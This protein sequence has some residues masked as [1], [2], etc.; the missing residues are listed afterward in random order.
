MKI[1]I[2]GAGYVGLVT[3]ACFAEMGHQVICLD[4]D[5]KKIESLQ[6]GKVP[7]YEPGLE[8]LIIRNVN[9]GRLSFTTDYKKGVENALFCFLAVPTPS[10]EEGSC[11]VKH[12]LEAAKDIAQF[13]NGYKIVVVKSTVP[14]G[15]SKLVVQKIEETLVK[16]DS[17]L[18]FDVVSNPEFLKEGDAIGDFMKPDRIVIGLENDKV[19]KLMR[20]LY[21]PFNLSRD[22]ILVMDIASSEMTKYASNAMLASRISFMNELSHVCENLGA[23]I[24]KVRLGMGADHRIGYA[25]LYSGAGFGGSCFPKDIKALRAT[26]KKTGSPT[27]LLDAIE[28][29][30]TRQ[31]KVLYSKIRNYFSSKDG[32]QGKKLAIWGLAFKPGTDDLREAPSVVL[33]QDLLNAG[34]H[35]RI[36]D[37]VAMENAK[38][39]FGDHVFIEWCKDEQEAAFG[40]DGIVLVTEWKQFRFV[41]FPALLPHMRGS[42]FFDG[43]NQYHPEEMQ[44]YGFDY[45]SIGRKPFLKK[46]LSEKTAI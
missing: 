8:E 44:E 45:F 7:I 1:L 15:T 24:Q 40:T 10:D 37:P 29:V 36:F 34:V 9:A 39:I 2:V 43:R 16:R 42:V 26:A 41:D 5:P 20:E 27:Q 4:I 33:I 35:L 22:R 30:N 12:V 11:D 17:Q 46:A 19:E 28:T 18:R 31:K 25:F 23:D 32:L 6:I 38:K 21:K 3:G 13:M 14:V